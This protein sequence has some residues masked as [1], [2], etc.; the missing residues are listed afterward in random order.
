MASTE[1]LLAAKKNVTADLMARA[2]VAGVGISGGKLCVYL[3][4]DTPDVRA[5]VQGALERLA[6]GIE[7]TI[8]PSG[9]FIKQ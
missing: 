1:E 2:A 6:P 5:D 4:T 9:K 8:A 7:T 3:A